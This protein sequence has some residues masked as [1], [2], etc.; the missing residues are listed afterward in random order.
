MHKAF[1]WK[2]FPHS[3]RKYTRLYG[4]ISTG[5]DRPVCCVVFVYCSYCSTLNM[6]SVLP[7]RQQIFLQVVQHKVRRNGSSYFLLNAFLLSLLTLTLEAIFPSETSVIRL[8]S[9]T[10]KKR[11]H[12]S[13][14]YL[15]V[16]SNEEVNCFELVLFIA[17]FLRQLLRHECH[18]CSIGLL[19]RQKCFNA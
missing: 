18:A 6:A 12:C 2:T 16:T 11:R 1:D 17:L 7:K 8:Y 13:T 15:F 9:V 14:P 4:V 3:V 5:T 10:L 19:C